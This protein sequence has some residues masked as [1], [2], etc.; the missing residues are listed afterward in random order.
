MEAVNK[1]QD[2][3]IRKKR[4]QV[5]NKPNTRAPEKEGSRREKSSAGIRRE[6]R[7][8]VTPHRV[9]LFEIYNGVLNGGSASRQA[10]LT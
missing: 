8:S 5:R 10:G 3:D 1:S 4:K 7:R 6:R 2:R 9:M